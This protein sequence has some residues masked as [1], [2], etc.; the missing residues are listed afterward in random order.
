MLY[1]ET[2]TLTLSFC[3]Q[4]GEHSLCWR[5]KLRKLL[6]V[7]FACI[8]HLEHKLAHFNRERCSN[9][10]AA[11]PLLQTNLCGVSMDHEPNKT[12]SQKIKAKVNSQKD[13]VKNIKSLAWI[14]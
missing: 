2:V 3:R 11:G 10:P 6:G 8:L 12:K 1:Q 5:R 4:L 9:L 7:K 14:S 13:Q